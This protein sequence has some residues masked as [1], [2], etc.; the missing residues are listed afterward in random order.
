[1]PVQLFNLSYTP[2]YRHVFL[3]EMNG[4]DEI[5]LAENG[6]NDV[7]D[8]LD[9]LIVRKHHD[10]AEAPPASAISV[11]DRDRL[12]A[13]IY[14]TYFGSMISSVLTCSSC[15]KPFDTDFSLDEL[16]RYNETRAVPTRR[17]DEGYFDVDGF[18]RFRLPSG[19]DEMAVVGLDA[20]QAEM[21][22]IRRC[23]GSTPS[24]ERAVK[25]QELMEQVAPLL[26]VETTVICPECNHQQSAVF[27]M[28]EFLMSRLRNE[29]QRTLAEI[30]CLAISYKWRHKEI[31]N[32][33]RSL[34]KTYSRLS[35]L[36]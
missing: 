11:A 16:A 26:F 29:Q 3:R 18:G 21:E 6:S 25:L 19:E 36:E 35:G 10:S 1:M 24:K 4:H 5:S 28:Q 7:L 14:K 2:G 30:H 23:M 13:A 34:R 8:F 17:D 9:R 15:A 31:L 32:L 33:T 12:L 27:D 22:L 20:S